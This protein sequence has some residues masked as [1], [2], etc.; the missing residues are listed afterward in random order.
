M[1]NLVTTIVLVAVSLVSFCQVGQEYNTIK[2][3]YTSIVAKTEHFKETDTYIKASYITSNYPQLE[4]AY[5]ENGKD[6]PCT[7]AEIVVPEK[8]GAELLMT[9][10]NSDQWKGN[11]NLIYMSESQGLIAEFIINK[12]TVSVIK[13]PLKK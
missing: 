10:I 4:F 6:K 11:G 9:F 12:N 3:F 8:N 5:F 2:E 1:R 7:K 13:T